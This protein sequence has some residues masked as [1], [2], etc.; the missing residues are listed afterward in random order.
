MANGNCSKCE[1]PLDGAH[2]AYCKA[3]AAEYRRN[4][5]AKDPEAARAYQRQWQQ[6][7]REK[8]KLYKRRSILKSQYGLTIE[9]YEQMVEDQDGQCAICKCIPDTPLFVDHDHGSGAIRGLLCSNCN[10]AIGLLADDP[11]RIIAAAEYV[12]HYSLRLVQEE[13]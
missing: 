11:D 13:S 7:N 8:A 6:A 2:K 5:W 3:C 12:Q 4:R 10:F 9:D 1:K